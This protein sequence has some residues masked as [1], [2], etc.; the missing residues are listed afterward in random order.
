MSRSIFFLTWKDQ[1][2]ASYAYDCNI[3]AVVIA[4]SE[5]EARRF[6]QRRTADEG[7]YA[8]DRSWKQLMHSDREAFRKLLET[9]SAT[10]DESAFWVSEEFSSCSVIGV[11]VPEAESGVVCV[12]FSAG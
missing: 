3:T 4:G 8:L 12:S 9:W 10:R 1:H 2:E 5:D 11:A 6:M 7:L